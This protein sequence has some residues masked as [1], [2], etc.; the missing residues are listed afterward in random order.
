MA[1]T[2]SAKIPCNPR[3]CCVETDLL[4]IS[5]KES[6]EARSTFAPHHVQATDPTAGC[7]ADQADDQSNSL[8]QRCQHISTAYKACFV[9]HPAFC[10]E[11]NY[12]VP[13]WSATLT[14]SAFLSRGDLKVALVAVDTS[15]H[16]VVSLLLK[17]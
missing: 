4:T 14:K 5:C 2:R 15:V 13:M 16:P 3:V 17:L 11:A 1:A 6:S 12:V 9:S 10:H 7:S 8:P